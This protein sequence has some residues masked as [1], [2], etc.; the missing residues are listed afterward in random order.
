MRFLVQNFEIP[1][2]YDEI[3]Q[4]N[5]G[6]YAKDIPLTNFQNVNHVLEIV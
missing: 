5:N 3:G 2:I 6:I 1:R 4:N